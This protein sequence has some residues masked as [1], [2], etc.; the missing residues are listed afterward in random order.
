[1]LYYIKYHS[2]YN[3]KVMFIYMYNIVYLIF[4]NESTIKCLRNNG[5]MIMETDRGRYIKETV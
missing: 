3:T 1:M 5:N 4:V 2:L